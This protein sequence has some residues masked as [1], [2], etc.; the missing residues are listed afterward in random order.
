MQKAKLRQLVR[1]AERWVKRWVQLSL[2]RG[3]VLLKALVRVV[4][5]VVEL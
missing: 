1:V 2:V 5:N 3:W 4:W